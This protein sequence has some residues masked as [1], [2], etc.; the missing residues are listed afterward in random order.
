MNITEKERLVLHIKH[1]I[2][3]ILYLQKIMGDPKSDHDRQIKMIVDTFCKNIPEIERRTWMY[4]G[5]TYD[6]VKYKIDSFK[7]IK[8]KL[9]MCKCYHSKS[10]H[11]SSGCIICDCSTFIDPFDNQ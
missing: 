9:K 10:E 3:Q 5:V 8:H 1:Q 2:N 7:E 6:E 4:F 11:D